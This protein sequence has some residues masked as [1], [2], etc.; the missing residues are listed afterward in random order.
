MSTTISNTRAPIVITIGGERTIV[1]Y[2]T[3]E[4]RKDGHHIVAN[5]NK[6]YSDVPGLQ[7]EVQQMLDT[8]ARAISENFLGVGAKSDG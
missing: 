3:I 8:T 5:I 1:G 7:A 6:R 4:E 2:S